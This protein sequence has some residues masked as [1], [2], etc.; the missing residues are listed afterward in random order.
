MSPKL[1]KGSKKTKSK[2]TEPKLIHLNLDQLFLDAS[3]PRFG[4]GSFKKSEQKTILNNI[5]DTFGV[6]DLLSSIAVNGYSE[7]EPLV[8]MMQ[9]KELSD[10][11][12]IKEGNRRLC[13]LLILTNDKRASDQKQR[14][15][16][17]QTRHL[18]YGSK[19]I[20]PVPV[21]V[22][23]SGSEKVLL[24]YLGVRHISGSQAWDSYAKAAWVAK[25]VESSETDLDSIIHMI[26]DNRDTAKKMLQA[27]YLVQQL[28]EN[29]LFFPEQSLRKGSRSTADFPFSWVYTA[30]GYASIRD[31]LEL[32]RE[33]TKKPLK[34]DKLEDG[35]KLFEWMF[36]QN[37]QPPKI[38]ESR[39][40]KTLSRII[41]KPEIRREI[42]SVS[43]IESLER[44]FNPPSKNVEEDL[45]E[46]R[47]RMTT[48]LS[49]LNEGKIEAKDAS[50]IMPLATS[51][52]HLAKNLTRQIVETMAELDE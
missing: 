30:I 50:S 18:E 44:N 6:Q 4:I 16:V 28:K 9:G 3:N 17:F 51:L 26:G 37:G 43:N 47:N 10:G 2:K 38:D 29:D 35:G 41:A 32:D 25:S 20:T 21:V 45:I 34:G 15:E 14:I 52:S 48:A 22:F 12:I 1:P 39:D 36:G 13:A 11:V 33:P 40:I 19:P 31:W 42:S 27:Y 23:P 8:G 24:P 5:V 7:A 49:V 46:A